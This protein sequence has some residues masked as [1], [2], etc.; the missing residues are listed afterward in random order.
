MP[1]RS[2]NTGD[3][4]YGFN[5]K[6]KDS[7]GEFGNTTYDYGFRIYNPSIG[8]FLS[9][10]PLTKEYPMLT[11][12]QFASNTPIYAIDLDG[13]EAVVTITQDFEDLGYQQTFSVFED[14][15][16]NGQ[17]RAN[18]RNEYPGLPT[19]GAVTIV[20]DKDGNFINFLAVEAIEIQGSPPIDN[21]ED[22]MNALGRAVERTLEPKIKAFGDAVEQVNLGAEFKAGVPSLN[23]GAKGGTFSTSESRAGLFGEVSGNV[24]LN[25]SS[26]LK[27]P[28]DFKFKTEF[29]LEFREKTFNSGIDAKSSEKAKFS[30]NLK[31][32]K[33]TRDSEG[34]T[35]L[36]FGIDLGSKFESTIGSENKVLLRGTTEEINL[37]N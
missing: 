3:Y 28:S 6:E 34:N 4:R 1:G 8:K 20:L 12:Y 7:N 26:V 13:L 18:L 37:G 2:L 15:D 22:A 36:S 14:D 11:P 21:F 32:F 35:K 24:D 5:A 27:D 10:D 30:L 9:V 17:T 25:T 33:M 29:F 31:L 19:S 16:V 23:I